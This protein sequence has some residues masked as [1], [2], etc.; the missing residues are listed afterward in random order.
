VDDVAVWQRFV[1]ESLQAGPTFRVIGVASDGLEAI[2]KAIKLQPDLILM[3]VGLPGL[4]GIEAARRIREQVPHSKILFVSGNADPD[5]VRSAF[6][7]GGS[8]YILKSDAANALVAGMAAVLLGKQF[9]SR[10]VTEF[11]DPTGP[12]E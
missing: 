7:A 8:G 3:D 11:D 6:E 10:S 4:D 9:V 12:D 1:S 2:H 5:V